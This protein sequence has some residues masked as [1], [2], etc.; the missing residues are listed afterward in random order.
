M[1]DPP[2]VGFWVGHA[3][4]A[5]QSNK[6]I[7]FSPIF[8]NI[9]NANPKTLKTPTETAMSGSAAFSQRLA[10]FK[11]NFKQ[12]LGRKHTGYDE[13]SG[14]E[15]PLV[16]HEDGQ[17][18]SFGQGAAPA[19]HYQGPVPGYEGANRYQP[20]HGGQAAD[21]FTTATAVPS[22]VLAVLVIRDAALQGW[23]AQVESV[24]RQGSNLV[25]RC[26]FY[27]KQV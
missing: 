8:A 15:R 11:E 9:F 23:R 4:F 7:C 22:Q 3:G 27:E 16:S 10:A 5:E 21:S 2:T 14:L 1:D 20:A 25:R 17:D 24:A 19:G 13:L 6:S 26:I 12:I 18:D